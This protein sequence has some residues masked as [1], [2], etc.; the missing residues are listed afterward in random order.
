MG[1][2]Q[3]LKHADIQG[4]NTV[5]FLPKLSVHNYMA[6]DFQHILWYIYYAH[7][8]ISNSLSKPIVFLLN[9]NQLY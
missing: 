9:S 6:F 1:N 3:L 8:T 7:D 2:K 5:L 4:D